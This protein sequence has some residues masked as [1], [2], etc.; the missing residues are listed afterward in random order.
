MIGLLQ[1]VEDRYQDRFIIIDSS[2][3]Q[4]AAETEVLGRFIDAVVLVVRY[5]KSARTLIRHSIDK[6][7]KEKFAGVV[8]NGLDS[9]K[10][11]GHYYNYLKYY[12]DGR[13]RSPLCFWRK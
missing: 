4:V 11:S 12:H 8:F 6:I 10:S 3:A 2:P 7:G 13:K 1:E 5:G 9:K